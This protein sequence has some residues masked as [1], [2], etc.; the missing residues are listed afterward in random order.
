[1]FLVKLYLLRNTFASIHLKDVSGLSVKLHL[2]LV[3]SSYIF[4]WLNDGED[5]FYNEKTLFDI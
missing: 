3:N 4:C 1:M 2:A 5:S